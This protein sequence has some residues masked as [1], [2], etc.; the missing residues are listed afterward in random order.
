MTLRI[1]HRILI[2]AAIVFGLILVVFALYKGEPAYHVSGVI[3]AVLA[4]GGGF[5]LRWFLKKNPR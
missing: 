2:T 5:Y 4:V 1:F 3:G